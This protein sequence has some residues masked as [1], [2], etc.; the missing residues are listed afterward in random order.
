MPRLVR[1]NNM[2]VVKYDTA[3]DKVKGNFKENPIPD[4]EYEASVIRKPGAHGL[5]RRDITKS[6]LSGDRKAQE[7]MVYER[8]WRRAIDVAKDIMKDPFIHPFAEHD[9]QYLLIL[10]IENSFQIKRIPK[11]E[12]K[13]KFMEYH[14]KRNVGYVETGIGSFRRYSFDS[15]SDSGKFYIPITIEFINSLKEEPGFE[16]V[17]TT[18]EYKQI[19]KIYA[20]RKLIINQNCRVIRF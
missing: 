6:I 11:K 18:L 12:M 19:E 9:G 3:E 10:E 2:Q 7:V 4:I 1:E 20:E 5:L 13:E 14:M 17:K 16:S 8:N 15:S